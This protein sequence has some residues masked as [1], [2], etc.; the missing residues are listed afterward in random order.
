DKAP[1]Q[2]TQRAA[3][4]ATGARPPPRGRAGARTQSQSAGKSPRPAA[5]RSG[6]GRA[7]GI[8]AGASAPKDGQKAGQKAKLPDD[9][10]AV[11]DQLEAKAT[12]M[13]LAVQGE[14]IALT[15]LDKVLWPEE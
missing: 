2:A 14:S 11:I 15:N 13:T 4:L 6:T 3:A 1:A 7:A 12:K 5:R 10:A 9:V 8:A